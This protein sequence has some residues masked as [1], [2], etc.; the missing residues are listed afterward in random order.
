MLK[1][2][3]YWL[4]DILMEVSFTYWQSNGKLI[5][6]EKKINDIPNSFWKL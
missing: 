5:K 2:P 4:T 1:K 6:S 3:Q